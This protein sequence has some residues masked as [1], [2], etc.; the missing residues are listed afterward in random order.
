MATASPTFH[1]LHTTSSPLPTDDDA[2]LSPECRKHAES[3]NVHSTF[4]TPATSVPDLDNPLRS[5]PRPRYPIRVFH[6]QPCCSSV[7]AQRKVMKWTHEH[8]HFWP[9]PAWLEPPSTNHMKDVAWPYLNDL[10]ADHDSISIEFLAEGGFNRVFTIHTIDATTRRNVD[11]IFRVALPVDPYYKTESDVATTEIVRHFTDIPV[12]TIYA[13]DSST[14]NAIGLEW[15]LMEKIEGIKLDEVWTRMDYNAKLRL[16]KLTALWASQLAHISTNKIGSIYMRETASTLDFHVGR[17]VH[18]LLTQENRLQYDVFRGPFLSLQDYYSSILTV[19]AQDVQ[20]LTQSFHSGTF[21]FESTS[22]KFRGTF[23]DQDRMYYLDGYPEWT[24]DQ[25]H[26]EQAKELEDVTE[27]V[28]A[29]R[30]NLP[31]LC[32]SAPESSRPLV[33]FLAHQDV[34]GGNIIVDKAFSPVG[35]LDWEAIRMLPALGLTNPPEF[36]QSEDEVFEPELDR[37]AYEERWRRRGISEEN[38]QRFRAGN[39]D[40][41]QRRMENFTGTQLRRFYRAELKRLGSQLARDVWENDSPVDRELLQRIE[42]ISDDVEGHLEWIRNTLGMYDESD[43]DDYDSE[44]QEESG[45]SDDKEY[46]VV[47]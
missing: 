2:S 9:D 22:S 10:G 41:F 35:L 21:R 26:A 15:M 11:Y 16:T 47:Y 7:A 6:G 28:K 31:A 40:S 19:T 1:P 29:L 34:S 45:A 27:A 44:D 5:I 20:N 24:D 43:S 46:A 32:A 3:L 38:K 25:W 18:C 8:C 42:G 30:N 13:F 23:L 37:E 39:E 36:I 4:L 33:T 17:N 14:N 12:P